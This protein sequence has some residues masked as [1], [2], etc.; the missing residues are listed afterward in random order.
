MI[1]PSPL[2]DMGIGGGPTGPSFS[3]LPETLLDSGKVDARLFIGAVYLKG[4]VELNNI[5]L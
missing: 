5:L 4:L 3:S 1:G 2:G